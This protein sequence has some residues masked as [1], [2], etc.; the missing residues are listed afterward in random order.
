MTLIKDDIINRITDCL[1]FEKQQSKAV[2]EN[3]I[4]IFKSSL[5]SGDEVLISGFGK[6]WV[7]DKQERLGRNPVTGHRMVLDARR[8]VRFRYSRGLKAK[9]NGRK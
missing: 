6:F 8:V 9:L 2:V 1:G 4:E 3:L 5:E 7:Q